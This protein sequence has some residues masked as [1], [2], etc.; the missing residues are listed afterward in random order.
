MT[1]DDQLRYRIMNTPD[2]EMAYELKCGI[3][4]RLDRN[5]ELERRPVSPFAPEAHV[6]CDLEI[7]SLKTALAAAQRERDEARTR[8]E[9]SHRIASALLNTPPKKL[10]EINNLQAELARARAAIRRQGRIIWGEFHLWRCHSCA[11]PECGEDCMDARAA[12]GEG[13]H[14]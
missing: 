13:D 7:D 10:E 2:S 9:Q 11:T 6:S 3:I 1:G 8:E 12:L 4:E 5:V 14:A